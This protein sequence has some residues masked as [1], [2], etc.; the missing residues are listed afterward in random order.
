[1]SESRDPLSTPVQFRRIV[2]ESNG[3]E[4][5]VRELQNPHDR[6][7]GTALIFERPAVIRKIRTFPLHWR[8]LSDDELIVLS[9]G[10]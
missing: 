4:W 2:R 10:T 1:M 5:L 9:L 7:N 8:T 3:D 6:R